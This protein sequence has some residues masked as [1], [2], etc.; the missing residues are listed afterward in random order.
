MDDIKN[1]KDVA[2]LVRTFY[3]QVREDTE[4]GPFF[5]GMISDWEEHFEKLTDFWESNLFL[6]GKYRGNPRIAHARVDAAFDHSLESRHFGVWLNIWFAT[7][8]S[9]YTGELAERAK[10]NARKMSTHLFMA[11]YRDRTN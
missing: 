3:K 4:I 5:N 6:K 10:H 2:H 11:I 1:R 7:V 8:D 9:L